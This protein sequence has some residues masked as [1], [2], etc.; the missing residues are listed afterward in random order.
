MGMARDESKHS[1]AVSNWSS[2]IT[3]NISRGY[4]YLGKHDAEDMVN[5]GGKHV[6]TVMI[7]FGLLETKPKIKSI[8]YL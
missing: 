5:G 3:N 2:K 1:I 8:R 4:E 7:W 6:L